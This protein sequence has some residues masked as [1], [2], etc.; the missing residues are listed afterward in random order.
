MFATAYD[1]YAIKA[2]EVNAIDY[3]LKPIT[4]DRLGTTVKRLMDIIESNRNSD[5]GNAINTMINARYRDNKTNRIPLWKNDRIHLISPNDIDYIEAKS[6]DTH[7]YT[8]KG[9]SYPPIH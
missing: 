9:H 2:F 5:A 4:E 3:L 8:K 6:G 1:E 7:I